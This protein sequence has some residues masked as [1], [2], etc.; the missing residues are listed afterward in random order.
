M[1]AF[2]LALPL[3]T[4]LAAAETKPNIIVILTDDLG[5]ADIGSQ[6][7]N[8]DI[9]TPNIDALAAGG[10]RATS[11]YVTAPQCVPSRAAGTVR[12]TGR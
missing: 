5:W 9:R 3:G 10:L 12:S 8:K 4:C 7:I 2:L 11:G 6:G 1:K